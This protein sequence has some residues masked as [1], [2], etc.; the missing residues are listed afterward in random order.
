MV[1]ISHQVSSCSLRDT[2]SGLAPPA[3]AAAMRSSGAPR[4][5]APPRDADAKEG[6]GAA[7]AARR[8]WLSA[9]GLEPLAP[10][11]AAPAFAL[12]LEVMECNVAC[13]VLLS[14]DGKPSL[15]SRSRS[16]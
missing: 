5:A 14:C 11:F 15:G 8:K 4:A 16:R 10:P 6:S 13:R 2:L 9:L 7:S 1:Y 3:A 12:S